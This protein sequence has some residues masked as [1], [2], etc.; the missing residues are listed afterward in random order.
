MKFKT[1]PIVTDLKINEDGSQLFYK[2]EPLY[3]KEYKVKGRHYLKKHVNFN[4]Q[5]HSFAKLICETWNEIRP[6]KEMVVKRRDFNPENY[7][8]TNLYWAPRGGMR[9]KKTKRVKTS[10]ISE[11]DIAV[12]I[13][14]IKAGDS[15]RTIAKTYNTSDMSIHRIKRNYLED[16]K[17]ILKRE[18]M[19]A[20]DPYYKRLAFAKYFGFESIGNAVD[21]FGRN[22]FILKCQN[23][24]L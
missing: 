21:A 4:N 24:A 3:S 20:R 16:K 1:H 13:E 18:I 12:I 19:K 6:N 22:Q 10:K 5:T 2:G 15:L 14:R 11:K 7:H 9:T 23:L 17:Q 8:Y